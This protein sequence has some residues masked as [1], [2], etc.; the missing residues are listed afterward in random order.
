[1]RHSSGD[2]SFLSTQTLILLK[3]NPSACCT[4]FC[5]GMTTWFSLAK[6]C[7]GP[8]HYHSFIYSFIQQMCIAYY[9]GLN[10]VPPKFMSPSEPQNVA[11]LGN[12]VFTDTGQLRWA[13]TGLGWALSQ[14]PAILMRCQRT[15]RHTGRRLCEDVGRDWSKA[16]TSQ[17]MPKIPNNHENLEQAMKDS[18]PEPLEEP[19]P[20]QCCDFRLAASRTVRFLSSTVLSH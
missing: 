19:W 13:Y 8:Q 15:H 1:M 4:S 7:Q 16:L 14:W 11:L 12:K 10:S 18:S 17:E 20:R 3:L 6:T 9:T 5:S 2:F